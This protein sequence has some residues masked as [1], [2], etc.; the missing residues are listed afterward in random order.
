MK[1][2]RTIEAFLAGELTGKELEKF[3]AQLT[4]DSLF[5]E[6]VQ[7]HYEVNESIH[8]NEIAQIRDKVR[9]VLSYTH[10][11]HTKIKL[12][13]R[14][15]FYAAAAVISL[16]IVLNIF[17]SKQ[18]NTTELFTEYYKPYNPDITL[19]STTLEKNSVQFAYKLY[20]DKEY[21]PAFHILDNYL[22]EHANDLTARFY[23]GMCALELNKNDIAIYAFRD[24]I[25]TNNNSPF[26]E[27]AEWYLGLTY[28]KVEKK[29]SA[30]IYFNRIIDESGYHSEKASEILSSIDE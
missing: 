18:N 30:K 25:E 2:L 23:Y 19:R 3:K 29:D 10:Q 12:Y 26:A 9:K 5:S 24:V 6:E 1:Q 15:A 16:L 20:Q 13:R 28:V 27:H 11:T 8:D 22:H 7:L 14:I 4:T 17:I 21:G